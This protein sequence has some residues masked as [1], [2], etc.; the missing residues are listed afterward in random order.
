[1]CRSHWTNGSGSIRSEEQRWQNAECQPCGE[2]NGD[3]M[4][5]LVIPDVHL[6]PDM[7]IRAAEL[8]RSGI[9]DRAVCL[10]DIAD[11]WKQQYNLDLYVRTYD[12]AISFAKE[13][14]DTL[15]CYGNHDLSY[16]WNQRESGYSL[17]A[18]RTVN[19][20][21]KELRESLPEENQLSYVHRID[22]VI[23]SHGGVSDTF[24]REC[25]DSSYYDDTDGVIETIN[26][27]GMGEMWYDLSPIWYRPQ[28][29]AGPLYKENELLQIVG[30]TPVRNLRREDNLISC[31]VFS[32]YSNGSSIGSREYLLLDTKTWEY[33]GG[34]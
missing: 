4:K 25:I 29:E 12:A 24:V 17:I 26:S 16:I 6:K 27:F 32:T 10:M 31:D 33:S 23:F 3:Y 20:K 7:F 9:A 5:V 19:E 18:P 2:G 28:Y 8:M 22:D 34:K 21:L 1:M 13:F 14:A 11:D 30:H 15:W